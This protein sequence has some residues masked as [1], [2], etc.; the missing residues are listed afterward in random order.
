M[1]TDIYEEIRNVQRQD[2]MVFPRLIH[3]HKLDEATRIR[4][5]MD[6]EARQ[7]LTDP[8]TMCEIA[9]RS[10]PVTLYD[11]DTGAMVPQ[12]QKPEPDEPTFWDGIGVAIC[13]GVMSLV[14]ILSVLTS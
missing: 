9:Q 10:K 3:Q 13:M 4:K 11:A 5:R 14:L 1:Q 7:R 2:D 6:A 12:P 8:M